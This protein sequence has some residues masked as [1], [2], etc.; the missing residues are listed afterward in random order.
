VH[1][2]RLYLTT[3]PSKEKATTTAE[4]NCFLEKADDFAKKGKTAGKQWYRPQMT[5]GPTTVSAIIAVIAMV[6]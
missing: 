2:Q 3:N 4:T 6:A 5:T 1:G